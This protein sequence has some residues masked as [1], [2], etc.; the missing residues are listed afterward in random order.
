MKNS[1]HHIL[2]NMVGSCNTAD[3]AYRVLYFELEAQEHAY[4]TAMA[5][6]LKTQAERIKL[7]AKLKS[8]DQVELLLAKADEI[9]LKADVARVEGAIERAEQEIAFIKMVMAEIDQYRK[10]KDLPLL[11][12]FQACQAEE[13]ALELVKRAKRFLITMGTIPQ[14]HFEAMLN[15]PWCDSYILPKINEL[16]L[17]RQ[18]GKLTLEQFVDNTPKFLAE[19]RAN[20]LELNPAPKV[21]TLSSGEVLLLEDPNA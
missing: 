7:D 8:E 13:W 10:Y 5:G 20:H 12:A 19:V 21:M 3:E 11:D 14:D 9:Q 2:T 17:L 15:H 6:R 18:A 1:N 16:T 4:Q